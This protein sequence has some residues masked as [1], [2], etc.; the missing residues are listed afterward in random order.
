MGTL[1]KIVSCDP[2]WPRHYVDAQHRLEAMLNGMFDR[3]EHV[4]STAVQ[5]LA[6]N[7]LSISMW[8]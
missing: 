6:A 7:L 4:G 3:M 8:R 2:D 5:G 1:V